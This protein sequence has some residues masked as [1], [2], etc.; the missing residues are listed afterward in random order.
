MTE[1]GEELGRFSGQAYE[2]V[3]AAQLFPVI[4][5][6]LAHDALQPVAIDCP[7]QV[8]ARNDQSQPGR[9]ERIGS[10]LDGEAAAPDAAARG[11][12]RFD[13]PSAQPLPL[14]VAPLAA[15]TPSLARPLARRARITAR[16]PRVRIRTRK[17][18]VRFL[19]TTE[20]WKVRFIGR[21]S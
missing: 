8:P 5:K 3:T 21:F 14:R 20:G 11:E 7:A 12:Q 4:A 16:P 9:A 15:Q 18:C 2:H 6:P 1:H 17:P 13:V 10:E 19:R